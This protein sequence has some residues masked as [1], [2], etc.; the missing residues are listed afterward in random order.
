MMAVEALHQC[1]LDE[2][3]FVV[4]G[5]PWQ[6][7]GQRTISPADVRCEMTEAA[8]AAMAGC[9][10][11]T[12]EVQRGGPSYMVDTLAQWS[13]SDVAVSIV[14]GADAA[15]GITTWHQ[16]E[17]LGD[18]AEIV[19]VGRCDRVVASPQAHWRWRQIDMARL[20]VSSSDL[21]ARRQAGRPI[22][23]L[24]PPLV[25]AIIEREHLYRADAVS[26]ASSNAVSQ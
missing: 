21:R 12:S 1:D 18:L 17:R 15:E 20:D 7:S 16:W 9:V 3:R 25:V 2:V 24:C 23:V 22:D 11:D 5:D 4:A 6:K 26:G 8:V 10:V 14:V 19:V 13:D